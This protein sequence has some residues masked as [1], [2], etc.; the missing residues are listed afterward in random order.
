MVMGE[1]SEMYFEYRRVYYKD[2][3]RRIGRKEQEKPVDEE[4]QVHPSCAIVPL[5]G[6]P[7]IYQFKKR[8]REQH[9]LMTTLVFAPKDIV[10][11]SL[12]MRYSIKPSALSQDFDRW[13]DQEP[14]DECWLTIRKKIAPL[15]R[16]QMATRM[17][18]YPAFTD[19]GLECFNDDREAFYSGRIWVACKWGGKHCVRPSHLV[20]GTFAGATA[21]MR[22]VKRG[23]R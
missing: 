6:A 2:E 1:R 19:P 8:E 5:E 14:G 3:G 17:G 18:L 22:M 20:V 9:R 4:E 12:M 21:G 23:D 7:P 16:R 11:E 15:R 13:R 10:F